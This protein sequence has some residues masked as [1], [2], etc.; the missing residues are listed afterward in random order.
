[1]K[2]L[3]CLLLSAAI[4]S[5]ANA[6]L[7]IASVFDGPLPGGLPK[8]VALHTIQNIADLSLYGIG[9][10][11]NGGGSDGVEFRLP[12]ISANAGDFI[13]ITTD[14]NGFT[15]FFGFE[16]EYTSSAV[17]INGNDAIELF[18]Q[19]TII[20]SFGD[21]NTDGSGTNWEYT[22]GWAH[23]V[24]GASGSA[25]FNSADWVFSRPNAWDNETTNATAATPL[26]L[27][28]SG[29]PTDGE[30]S[31][32]ETVLISAIQGTPETHLTNNYNETDVSP[33]IG[34][35]VT[36][37]AIVVGDFQDND[38]DLTRNLSGFFIQEEMGDEDGNVDSSEGLFIY[39][40]DTLVDVSLGD[41][42]RIT[43]DVDQYYGETQ[44][45]NIQSIIVIENNQLDQVAPAKISLL[46][47]T[48]VSMSQSGSYQAEL[49]AY[50]GMLITWVD[51][52]MVTEQFQLDRFNEIR[53][54][55]GNRPTQFT[56]RNAPDAQHYQ[57]WLKDIGGRSLVYDDGLNEQNVSIG[58]LKGYSPYSEATA[59]RM[60]D[61]AQGLTGVLDYK[62]AGNNASP[63]TWRLRA[64]TEG[65]NQFTSTQNGNSLNP[66]PLQAPQL[67]GNLKIASYNLLN[68]FSTIDEP[69]VVTAAGH[70]PR[71]ADSTEEFKR[72]L[73]KTVNA[74]VAIDADIL[75]L[76]ELEN[77]FDPIN[78][79]NTAIEI[80]V[81]AINES[82]DGN[83]Y[84]YVYPGQAFVGTDAIAVAAIYKLAS[85][86]LAPHTAPAMLTDD[87]AQTF[88]MFSHQNFSVD[89]IFNGEATNR[90]SLA[91]SFQHNATGDTFTLAIN[92][93]KS[94]GQ[95]Q[96]ENT[97]SVNFD[98]GDGAGFWN[99]RRTDAAQA[100]MFWLNQSPTGLKDSDV[101]ILGDLNAYAQEPPVQYL[102]QN[103]FNNVASADAYSYVFDGQI[104]T[105]DYLLLSNAFYEKLSRAVVWHINTDEAD[106][107]D[108]NLDYGRNAHYFNALTATRN[109]DH[110]PVI[111]GL[112]MT[113]TI[114][115]TQTLINWFNAQENIGAISGNSAHPTVSRILTRLFR[116][117]LER[118]NTAAQSDNP[119]ATC[120]LLKLAERFSD[121]ERRPKDFV[122]GDT[123]EELNGEIA[124]AYDNT[125]TP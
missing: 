89:P 122:K 120:I 110:D 7:L 33:L 24:E 10:A 59:K 68:L 116:S 117:L 45:S 67:A 83:I 18:F 16:P 38:S 111:A 8:G 48:K 29:N 109:S 43:G 98:K 57:A 71:G 21:A 60:G 46:N 26:P 58:L 92:H 118:A 94:K 108:Y 49:E 125:C 88:P 31:I 37:N 6:N 79:G 78:D 121:G 52:A 27:S 62:W 90:V 82:L 105:L 64:H 25:V 4:A 86:H 112:V 35:T 80:L 9:S 34:E 23:R 87:K 73:Q 53:M 14:A 22:D 104:G 115:P 40:P 99:Q 91:V 74:I 69:D 55:A 44:L 2:K 63:A 54:A 100:L 123:V 13:Y 124:S 84:T 50:E 96:L 5:H 56:Q 1:M 65:A 61:T 20:D 113:S 107:L 81:N 28:A 47:N 17:N 36:I 103:G 32:A 3:T 85:V 51:E 72:Q 95:S 102:L 12:Q 97:D 77:E 30:P 75:G 66:R 76:V 93:F 42:V 11:N 39:D 106:A 114:L 41:Q 70:D 15:D 19:D 101:A 119:S